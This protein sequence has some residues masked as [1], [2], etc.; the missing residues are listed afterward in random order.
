MKHT[1]R[2]CPTSK[3]VTFETQLP[4]LFSTE[5]NGF[6]SKTKVNIFQIR[7][8]FCITKK[9]VDLEEADSG[10][11]RRVRLARSK[12]ERVREDLGWDVCAGFAGMQNV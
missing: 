7:P 11:L 5:R 4:L 3:G 8:T 9:M 6:K 2:E 12:N 10:M 1:E